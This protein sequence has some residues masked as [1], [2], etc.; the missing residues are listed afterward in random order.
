[1]KAPQ[2]SPEASGNRKGRQA[3]ASPFPLLVS[4]LVLSSSAVAYLLIDSS[5]VILG[6]SAYFLTSVGTALC[7]AWDSLAQRRGMKNPNFTSNRTQARL[8]QFL[9]LGGVVIAAA[10]IFKVS[11]TAAEFLSELWGL[12]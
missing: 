8:L 6:L 9:A 1:M 10:H 5:Q 3:K 11:E 2:V 12:T 7:L 4:V